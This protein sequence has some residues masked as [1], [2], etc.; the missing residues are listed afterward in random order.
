M[1]GQ[2]QDVVDLHVASIEQL[3]TLSGIGPV[4]AERILELRGSVQG[5]TM[6]GLV[7]ASGK[8]AEYW[9]DL[10]K[11]GT[12]YFR[13][14]DYLTRD[15]QRTRSGIGVYFI[16]RRTERARIPT[17]SATRLPASAAGGQCLTTNGNGRKAKS[18]RPLSQS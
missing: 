3:K 10:Y 11:V 2:H 8:S 4:R 16:R 1:A 15:P 18:G 14:P 7:V 6:A 5:L 17:S 9:L 13:V 12:V